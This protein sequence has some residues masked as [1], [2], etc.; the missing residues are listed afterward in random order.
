MK[1]LKHLHLDNFQFLTGLGSELAE[2]VDV[3][4]EK[5]AADHDEDNLIG[6][7]HDKSRAQA[8]APGTQAD[9]PLRLIM[10][11]ILPGST[12]PKLPIFG[13]L[14]GRTNPASGKKLRM[15]TLGTERSSSPGSYELELIV[16]LGDRSE[17][18]IVDLGLLVGPVRRVAGDYV[19][20]R[21]AFVHEGAT[22]VPH[23]YT[24]ITR[25]GWQKRYSQHKRDAH[26]A[27]PYLFHDAIRRFDGNAYRTIHHVLIAGLSERRAMEF[28]EH[29]AEETLYPKGL[30]M[31]PGGYAGL[32]YLHKLGALARDQR[33]P[34][35]RRGEI[36][37]R[38]MQT[39]KREGRPNP[40]LAMRWRSD[41]DFA[42][43]I[44]CGPDGRLKPTQIADARLLASRGK[45]VAEIAATVGAKK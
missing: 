19:S 45:P 24:G 6:Q 38:F 12:V 23:A 2:V 15:V 28:E 44:I 9:N 39:A 34:V 18:V 29:F 8:R 13:D 16:T 26:S 10:N 36:V 3:N 1:R 25:Q 32:A 21:H 41:D 37:G 33:A 31:I 14:Q 11:V 17:Q 35:E 43:R 42:A 27:S 30:N 20:Y 5:F 4:L 7:L 22:L 40:L